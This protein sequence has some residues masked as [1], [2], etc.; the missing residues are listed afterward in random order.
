MILFLLI[1]KN[2][3]MFFIMSLH[4]PHEE[5]LVDVTIVIHPQGNKIHQKTCSFLQT[6][7]SLESIHKYVNR[8]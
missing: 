5:S 1:S 7:K 3:P 6:P 2:V 8:A 4:Y